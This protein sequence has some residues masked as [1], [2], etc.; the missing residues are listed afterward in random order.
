MLLEQ[1]IAADPG[2]GPPLFLLAELKAQ[3]RDGGSALALL[4]KTLL[5]PARARDMPEL[6]QARL[7]YLAATL[8]GDSA[9]AGQALSRWSNANPNDPEVWTSLASDEL[10]RHRYTEAV[11]SNQKA[12]VI[13]PEN[14]NALNQ[15]GYSAAYA[16]HL[17]TAM[18]AL[19]RYRALRPSDANPVDSMGDANLLLG[20][21]R[22]AEA[23]YLQAA[24]QD[25]S[26]LNGGD[27]FKAAMARLM[28]GDV[29][30]ADVLDKQFLD[31]HAAA[32]DPLTDYHRAQWQWSSGRRKAGYS[33]MQAFA[34]SAEKSGFRGAASEAYSQL[35]IWSVALSD[36]V[37]AAQL[38]QKA[39]SLASPLTANLAGLAGFLA[40]PS[41][42][43]AE[44]EA[45]AIHAFP[46]EAQARERR[47]A[48]SYALLI[49]KQFAAAAKVLEP[50]YGRGRAEE[51]LPVLL[52]WAY[53]ESGKSKEA[54]GLL[55][56]NPIPASTGV[57]PLSVFEF[58]RIAYL[59]GRVA[60]QAGNPDEAQSYYKLFRKLSGDEP[61]MWGEEGAT[62]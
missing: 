23:F 6:D 41:A 20:R 55:R 47:V 31:A 7:A 59:R 13:E 34:Q 1:A 38:A 57:T 10:T 50:L 58:P 24:K 51:G 35:A 62:K 53:L 29:E 3:Q 56:F 54:A 33:Q 22:E 21:L 25:R 48:L 32:K 12:L 14:V 30:G 15:L 11:Q 8:Q 37:A 43:P 49:G 52:G 40:Q 39:A 26:F 44:W 2:F 36:R 45:R 28:S 27:F 5:D 60:A 16:G 61:L 17:D 42:S 9:A 19:E 46:A 4:H 18:N